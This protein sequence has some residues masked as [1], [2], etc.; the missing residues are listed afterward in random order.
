[1]SIGEEIKKIKKEILSV[2][3]DLK[4][5]KRELLTFINDLRGNPIRENIREI[6]RI[7]RTKRFRS[8]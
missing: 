2:R 3:N 8:D 7:R 6:I 1:M 5:T 4:E